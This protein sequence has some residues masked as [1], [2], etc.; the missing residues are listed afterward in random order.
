MSKEQ[1]S[2]DNFN[3]WI[4]K[5]WWCQPWSIVLTGIT[6]IGTSWLFW[7]VLWLSILAALAIAIWWVYFLLLYPRMVREMYKQ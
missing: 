4:Y 7:H 2:A 1:N 5:P 6:V 3:I